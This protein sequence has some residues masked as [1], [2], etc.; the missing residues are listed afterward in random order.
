MHI[1]IYMAK[2]R[3]PA[4]LICN[5]TMQTSAAEISPSSKSDNADRHLQKA[6][7][8]VS[9]QGLHPSNTAADEGSSFTLLHGTQQPTETTV[10]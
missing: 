1:F 7:S 4:D 2:K 10:K 5:S 3:L 9:I 6:I 8:C